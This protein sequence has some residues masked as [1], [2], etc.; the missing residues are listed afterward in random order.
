MFDFFDLEAFN[1]CKVWYTS[2]EISG[3][4][5]ARTDKMRHTQKWVTTHV[6]ENDTPSSMF[7][8][9][10]AM[11]VTYSG[12]YVKSYPCD[13]ILFRLIRPQWPLFGLSENQMCWISY[14]VLLLISYTLRNFFFCLSRNLPFH[15]YSRLQK[16]WHYRHVV[17]KLVN[18]SKQNPSLGLLPFF[19]PVS[20]SWYILSLYNQWHTLERP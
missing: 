14:Y 18:E 12:I 19:S 9:L 20:G 13:T 15:A 4:F 2:F 17:R 1:I 5:G 10:M 6:T 7:D 8:T 11:W 3:D 16:G